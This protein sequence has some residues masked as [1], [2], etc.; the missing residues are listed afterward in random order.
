MGALAGMG[1][2]GHSHGDEQKDEVQELITNPE[3]LTF[4]FELLV[5]R[6]LEPKLINSERSFRLHG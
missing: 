6:H 2:H 4:E 3:E 1:S 5:S